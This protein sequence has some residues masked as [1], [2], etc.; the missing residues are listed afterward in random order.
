MHEFDFTI[1]AQVIATRDLS[2]GTRPAQV[3]EWIDSLPKVNPDQAARFFLSYLHD[4]NQAVLDNTDHFLALE[5]L[6]KTG[7]DIVETLQN[8][9]IRAALPLSDNNLRYFEHASTIC[10]LMAIG[11][12]C[13]LSRN[14]KDVKDTDLARTLL[15]SLFHC[16]SHLARLIQEHYLVYRLIP[17]N[18]WQEI[19]HLY[20]IAEQKDLL[21]IVIP[22]PGEK[23]EGTT[24]DHEYKRIILLALA[25]PYHLMQDEASEV[26][27]MLIKLSQGITITHYPND[28]TL[29]NGFALDL[30]SD[31]P[32]LFVSGQRHIKLFQP[33]E[34]NLDRLL[35]ALGS[36]LQKLEK[37]LADI[38][39]DGKSSLAIRLK[40]DLYYRLQNS[41]S[42]TTDRVH[43]RKSTLGKLHAAI[44]LSATHY[45]VSNK[46]PFTPELDEIINM[47]GGS[48]DLLESDFHL[49]PKEHE[50][51]KLEEAEERIESGV[52]VFRSSNFD[53]EN[54]AIDLWEK[55]YT[56][57]SSRDS[58]EITAMINMTDKFNL[59]I[60]ELRN[61]SKT[62][63]S[64][65]CQTEKIVHVRVGEI[66]AIRENDSWVLGNIRWLHAGENRSIDMGIMLITG[67]S[68]PIAAR[69]VGGIGKGGE[70]MR[71]LLIDDTDLHSVNSKILVPASIYDSKSELVINIRGKISYIQLLE[72][73]LSTKSVSIFEFNVVGVSEG[74]TQRIMEL[75]KLIR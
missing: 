36:H 21:N 67:T 39:N 66:M 41:W 24:I 16:I 43:P 8:K 31:G 29:E 25:N 64:L 62:G 44:G 2:H 19:H 54:K 20:Y 74:E 57:R 68:L 71:C 10:K 45:Q 48:L 18:V 17:A 23:N 13:V 5:H 28:A 38:L 33:R 50:P 15:H 53:D 7:F 4:L 34:L 37:K 27:L 3:D 58:D 11:Y 61:R 35:N 22:L 42:R 59:T 12:K 56:V 9:Y 26:F 40:R 75:N 49:M 46:V 1:P 14:K 73:V 32:P 69:A 72:Q 52:D 65:Y 30:Q 55:I 51:W 63:L 70:Y 6:R 60:W 47:R